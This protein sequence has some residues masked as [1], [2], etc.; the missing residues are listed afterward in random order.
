[1]KPAVFNHCVVHIHSPSPGVLLSGE[2][3]VLGSLISSVGASKERYELSADGTMITDHKTGLI[4]EAVEHEFADAAAAEAHVRG[5]RL[6]GHSDWIVADVDTQQTI[7]DRSLREPACDPIFNSNG[8]WLL[9]STPYKAD[10]NKP[11]GSSGLVW[12]VLFSYGGVHNGHRSNRCW[13][14]AVRRVSPAGQ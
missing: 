14:Q 2:P 7:L 5:L 4:W 9:T 6:G 12:L 11:A 8:G 1:M 10:K 13:C 3:L